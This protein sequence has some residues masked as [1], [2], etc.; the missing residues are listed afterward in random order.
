MKRVRIVEDWAI[1]REVL[2]DLSKRLT[3][4]AKL[5]EQFTE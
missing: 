2:K 4:L 3:E 1:P 5:I